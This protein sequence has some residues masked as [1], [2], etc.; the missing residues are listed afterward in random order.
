M[1]FQPESKKKKQK[2]Q[3]N[4]TWGKAQPGWWHQ[5]RRLEEDQ[6]VPEHKRRE[7]AV[8]VVV[9]DLFR[10]SVCN[11]LHSLF[12]KKLLYMYILT[13]S[14][15]PLSVIFILMWRGRGGKLSRILGKTQYFMNTLYL[16]SRLLHI[17]SSN[18]MWKSHCYTS[19]PGVRR[20][21]A[22]IRRISAR[23]LLN[24]RRIAGPIVVR[25]SPG[26]SSICLPDCSPDVC[27]MSAGLF[28]GLSDGYFPADNPADI[29]RTSGG[30]VADPAWYWPYPDPL[31]F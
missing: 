19:L 9:G 1:S 16:S 6:R 17:C 14:V 18:Q 25:M 15:R 5:V 30:R 31:I 10:A 13:L 8:V 3:K 27:W 29:W 12:G 28:A 2:K 20:M 7:L 24:A 22:S 4:V 11:N 23:C 26:L 21:S